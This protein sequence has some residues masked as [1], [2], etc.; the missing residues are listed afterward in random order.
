MKN[1]DH[2][3]RIRA[4]MVAA[5]A[6]EGIAVTTKDIIVGEQQGAA[7]DPEYLT[8]SLVMPHSAW[9]AGDRI[10]RALIGKL[11]AEDPTAPAIHLRSFVTPEEAAFEA[12]MRASAK[13]KSKS[14][15]K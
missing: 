5:L 4:R 9:S 10:A 8:V 3:E 1:D 15:S 7:A 6:A 14:K 12:E 11:A 2:A 13:S